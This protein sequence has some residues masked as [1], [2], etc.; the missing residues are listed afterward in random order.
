MPTCHHCDNILHYEK[1][2]DD[3]FIGRCS[4]C[5]TYYHLSNECESCKKKDTLTFVGYG[6]DHLR[7]YLT[8]QGHRTVILNAKTT[9][10]RSK[11]NQLR[12]EWERHPVIFCATSLGFAPPPCPLKASCILDADLFFRLGDHAHMSHGRWS[13]YHHCLRGPNHIVIQTINPHNPLLL[14][15]LRRKPEEFREYCTNNAKML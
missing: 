14:M 2:N 6:L 9:N 11:I 13:L 1:L 3:T 7:E 5:H 15:L 4:I 12:H 10:S 8:N